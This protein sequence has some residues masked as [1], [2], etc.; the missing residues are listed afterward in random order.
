VDR[1]AAI[2]PG[3]ELAGERLLPF[4]RG[5]VQDLTGDLEVLQFPSGHSNL[6]YLLRVGDTELV[7]RRPPA[8]KK[9]RSGHDMKR[10]YTVLSALHG[11]FPYCPRPLVF[12]DDESILGCPFYVMERLSGVIIRRT[13][14]PRMLR[15]RNDV[16]ALGERLVDVLAELHN[17]DYRA[18]G[19]GEF[20]RPEEYVQRQVVGWS[21]RYRQAKTPDVPDFEDVMAWLTEKMPASI[22]RACLIHNDYKLDN[23]VLD[24]RQPTRIIG[25]LD[26]EMATI[27]D[28]LMDLGEML[29][30]WVE[31]GDPPELQAM[32]MSPSHV[33]GALTRSEIAEQYAERTGLDVGRLDFYYCFGLFRIAAISQQIYYRYFKGQ[34]HDLRFGIFSHSV[35]ALET[36]CR[37]IIDSSDL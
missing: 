2:R 21:T 1:P 29:A 11:T 13:I 18:L 12:T 14:P 9:P 8:G 10:E 19:L 36:A 28:P 25:V 31:R 3:E 33:R 15:S 6:T 24:P 16:R 32:R 20:G 35:S 23:V 5:A 7:L 17:L 4:L 27:G 34:S 30:Y 37:R 22:D 26:W